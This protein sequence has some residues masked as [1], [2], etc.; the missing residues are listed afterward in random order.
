VVFV[1]AGIGLFL[2]IGEL[3]RHRLQLRGL[4]KV[5]AGKE[6]RRDD[7]FERG[8]LHQMEADP[9]HER[10]QAMTSQ[11]FATT[12]V[13]EQT[14]DEAFAAITDVRGWWSG[15][16]EGRTDALNEEFTYR[17]E[18]VHYT[19]QRISEL[20]PGRK[21]VWQIIESS[22]SFTK[23]PHEWTGTQVVFEVVPH[24]EQTEVRFAHL[25]LV[26]EF[27]CYDQCSSAWGFYINSSLKRLIATGQGEPNAQKVDA[28]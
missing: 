18:D 28:A 25:G 22:L 12:F 27:E 10:K 17:Y 14:P 2:F 23:D 26:P 13:V 3:P 6:S 21:V 7:F 9:R 16:I 5:V 8:Q 20:V 11:N 1:E 15:E 24:G 19:K 4:Q